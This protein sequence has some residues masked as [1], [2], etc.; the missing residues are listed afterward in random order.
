[1][2]ET[3]K[4]F[5][6]RQRIGFGVTVKRKGFGTLAQAI[7]ELELVQTYANTKATWV[8]DTQNRVRLLEKVVTK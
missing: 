1:M 6:A 4:F 3:N 5:T 2:E 8:E 7:Q